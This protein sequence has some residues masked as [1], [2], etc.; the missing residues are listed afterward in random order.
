MEIME[1][2][3]ASYPLF[4]DYQSLVDKEGAALIRS[5]HMKQARRLGLRGET[6][7][8][9]EFLELYR[10]AYGGL[11]RSSDLFSTMGYTAGRKHKQ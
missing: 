10:F 9:I 4:Q 8:V 1:E 11:I 6:G 3:G 7:L 2:L 5:G